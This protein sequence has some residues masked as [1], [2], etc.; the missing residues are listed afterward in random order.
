MDWCSSCTKDVA[1]GVTMNGSAQFVKFCPFCEK[2]IGQALTQPLAD[3]DR[4]QFRAAP[5]GPVPAARS[6]DVVRLP[7][8]ARKGAPAN[9]SP[10]QEPADVIGQV[11]SRLT[12]L[13]AEIAKRAGLEVEAKQLRKMLAVADRVAKES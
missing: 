10:I 2:P 5:I 9:E 1:A 11:R 8:Q 13:E 7:V 12:Y 6:A 4:S 3:F